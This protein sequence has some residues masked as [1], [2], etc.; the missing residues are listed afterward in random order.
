MKKLLALYAFA[1][2]TFMVNAQSCP[3]DNH[4]HQID[5]GLPSGTKWACC[6]VDTDNPENQCPTNNGGYYAWGETETK[7]KYN[8]NTYILCDGSLTT[9]YDL[10][11][12]ITN[13]QYDVAHVQWGGVWQMPSYDQIME[14]ID[15]CTF[16]WSTENGTKGGKF[17]SKNNGVSIFL[18]AAGCR[19]G[20]NLDKVGI[21]GYYWSSDIV[22][23][24]YLEYAHSQYFDSRF[25]IT[26]FYTRQSGLS[27]RPV[28]YSLQLSATTLNLSENET[29][30]ITIISG[31]GHYSI[32][33]S[34]ENVLIASIKDNSII[35]KSISE[36]TATITVTDTQ[37]N[38]KATI[39][40]YVLDSFCPD[41]NHPH[42]IDLGLPSGTLWACCNVGTNTPY[43]YG[44]YYAWGETVEKND[45][46][47]DNSITYNTSFEDISGTNYDVA[48]VKWGDA[49]QMPTWTDI[50]ELSNCTAIWEEHNGFNGVKVTG[51]NGNSIFLIAGGFKIGIEHQGSGGWQQSAHYWA[52]SPYPTS[53]ILS[54]RLYSDWRGILLGEGYSTGIRSNGYL[55]RPISKKDN[56]I[57]PITT[58]TQNLVI[59]NLYGIKVADKAADMN[60]LPPGIYIVNGK[61]M[62][63]K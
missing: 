17:T 61:K 33:S 16:E 60:T 18:P 3:D 35:L 21:E 44:S 55:I 15:N 63:I 5:L 19:I 42:M 27:V 51:K 45:Y 6:N 8:W 1:L 52:G 46:N 25:T 47:Q 54:Y 4:P 11:P 48:H 7:S 56:L 38:Q 58:N 36:G 13:T 31:S 20:N 9:C 49:W 2:V 10:S 30:V 53:N 12:N 14:L 29:K 23:S 39:I 34:D 32:E 43:D 24:Y 62:V 59:Y 28:A 40:V 26:N 22:P 50:V 37:Y 57:N 41:N